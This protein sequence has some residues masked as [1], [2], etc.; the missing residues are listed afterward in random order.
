M[1]KSRSGVPKCTSPAPK[2]VSVDRGC[3][4]LSVAEQMLVES[5]QALVLSALKMTTTP[6]SCAWLRPLALMLVSFGLLGLSGCMQAP[7]DPGSTFSKGL[8]RSAW[9]TLEDYDQAVLSGREKM[10]A[11]IP[12]AY[13]QPDIKRLQPVK[14][15][16][17]RVNLVV[18]QS[19]RD[20]VEQGKYINL[21]VSS[22]LP[23]SH[24]FS[25]KTH[26][27]FVFRPALGAGVYHF[28]RT[29]VR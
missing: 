13:W 29:A 27:G 11:E 14:V 2:Y 22:W 6:H 7:A 3:R 18:V 26:D 1:V 8:Q 20:G 10:R 4:H 12:A 9:K 28:T 5:S 24:W 16:S 17:H 15:Y 21:P 19:L 25:N 23:V